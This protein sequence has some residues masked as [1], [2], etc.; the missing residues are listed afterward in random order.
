VNNEELRTR[1]IA[2]RIKRKLGLR[3]VENLSGVEKSSLWR[4]EHGADVDFETVARIARWL[5]VTLADG[6]IVVSPE[7]TLEAILDVVKKDKRLTDHAKDVLCD[8]FSSAYRG[9]TDSA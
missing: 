1:L 5:G 8:I 3:S 7:N 6:A 4:F 2:E 9:A